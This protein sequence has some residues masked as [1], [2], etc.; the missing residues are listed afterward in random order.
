MKEE[1][2]KQ[3]KKQERQHLLFLELTFQFLYTNNL[4]MHKIGFWIMHA[5]LHS[6]TLLL[7]FFKK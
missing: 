7:I 3:T 4:F 2:T 6:Y 5:A 1:K